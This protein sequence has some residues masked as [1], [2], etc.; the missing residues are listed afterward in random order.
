MTRWRRT[1][2]AHADPARLGV[3]GWSYG[4]ILTNYV[5]AQDRRLK[6]AVSGAGA[7]NILAGSGPDG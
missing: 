1:S 7:S 4:A 2:P 5:I 3:G 6:A